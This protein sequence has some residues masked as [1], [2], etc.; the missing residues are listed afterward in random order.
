MRK[1]WPPLTSSTRSPGSIA[2]DVIRTCVRGGSLD[3]LSKSELE[4]RVT[5]RANGSPDLPRSPA[6]HRSG[7]QVSRAIHRVRVARFVDD[8]SE[9][10]IELVRCNESRAIAG[11]RRSHE[12]GEDGPVLRN[13]LDSRR[14]VGQVS[15]RHDS[16]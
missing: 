1:P 8:E 6:M 3:K 15:F 9:L 16:L 13:D 11:G 5:P 2:R 4:E 14:L 12:I 10:K 7:K